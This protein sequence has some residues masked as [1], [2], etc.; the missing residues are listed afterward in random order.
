VG[1]YGFGFQKY[2]KLIK[3]CEIGGLSSTKGLFG[4]QEGFWLKKPSLVSYTYVN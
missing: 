2:S 1:A 3:Y 4:L